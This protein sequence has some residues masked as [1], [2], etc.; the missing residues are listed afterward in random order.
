MK[1]KSLALLLL[2]GIFVSC[3]SAIS[4]R[5]IKSEMEEFPQMVVSTI[6]VLDSSDEPI[7]ELKEGDF[8]IRMDSHRGKVT[9]VSTYEKSDQGLRIMLCID[10]SGSMKG[11]PINAVKGAILPFIDR[12]RNSDKV[13]ISVYED[14][15][16]LLCDFTSD[17]GL[18]RRVINDIQPRGNYTSFYYGAYKGLEHL[19]NCKDRAGKIMV[20]L[21]DGKDENPNKSYKEDDVIGLAKEHSIPIFGVG[22]TRVDPI[23]LQSM[24]KMS[25][26][27]GGNF[28]HAPGSAELERHFE[29]LSRQIN[30]IYL[31]FYTIYDQA[32]DGKEHDLEI[33]VKTEMGEEKAMAKVSV[34]HG[35]PSIPDPGEG[36]SK[37]GAKG[38][39]SLYLIISGAALLLIGLILI[40]L[41][42]SKKKRRLEEERRAAQEEE[43][44]AAL[45]FERQ[46]ELEAERLQREQRER[47]ADVSQTEMVQPPSRPASREQTLILSPD[48]ERLK[49][50]FEYGALAGQTRMIPQSGA[51]IGRAP[52]NDIV[53]SEQTVSSHHARISYASGVFTIE[54]LGSLNGVYING[55]KISIHRLSGSCIFRIGGS[56][57]RFSIV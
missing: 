49:M 50:E 18:L 56:E 21:G 8:E 38:S 7:E 27:T 6:Q 16:S 30:K 22:F 13:S 57:G 35:K 41:M 25:E 52:D 39:L 55:N 28:Y 43:K 45:A 46:R 36:K 29:K 32:G 10:I 42:N 3:L 51:T 19:V 34:P 2:T 23:Y 48:G 11:A 12:V 31:L 44:R 14:G 15:Y 53:I 24:E 4:V 5:H 40:L 1:R 17:K 33:K 26:Q 54:D 20:L 47:G 37:G 9:K